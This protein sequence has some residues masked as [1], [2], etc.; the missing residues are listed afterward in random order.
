MRIKVNYAEL[1][2]GPGYN[3]TRAEAEIE[4]E[5]NGDLDKA[6]DWAWA[7]AQKEVKRQLGER[8]AVDEDIMPF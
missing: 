7:R 2:S 3:H 4:I 5:V 1:K 8:P 6:F